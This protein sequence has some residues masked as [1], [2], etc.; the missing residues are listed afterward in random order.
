[1]IKSQEGECISGKK[2][3]LMDPW[4]LWQFVLLAKNIAMLSAEIISFPGT[5]TKIKQ[6]GSI[7]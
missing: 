4:Q 5:D 2:N 1:M 7:I 3:K 6:K